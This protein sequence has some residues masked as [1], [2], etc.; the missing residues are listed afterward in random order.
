MITVYVKGIE[1]VQNMLGNLANMDAYDEAMKE[2]AITAMMIAKRYA[3]VDTG[4]LEQD[5]HYYRN[6]PASYTILADPVD[7][8]GRHYAVYN[9]YGT[10]KMP[11]GM[12]DSPLGVISTS[13]KYAFRPFMRPA[14]IMASRMA[15][16][17]LSRNLFG[18]L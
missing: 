1:K 5:I 4:M 9:E 2:I 13:G 12:P 6:G 8:H 15:P 10:V 3:P 14:A 16:S 7:E 18:K 11:A 17:I